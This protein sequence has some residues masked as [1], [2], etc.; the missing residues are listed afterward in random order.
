MNG[1]LAFR[2]A[3]NV[4]VVRWTGASFWA[5]GEPR[6][7]KTLNSPSR[8][9]VSVWAPVRG[10]AA[11][12]MFSM[13]RGLVPL[14]VPAQKNRPRSA[15]AKLR[16]WSLASTQKRSLE[17]K[18]LKLSEFTNPVTGHEAFSSLR[19]T[20]KRYQSFFRIF[21]GS[22]LWRNRRRQQF[23]HL[24]TVCST[25]SSF[26]LGEWTGGFVIHT[27]NG[28]E[29]HHQNILFFMISSNQKVK[30]KKTGRNLFSLQALKLENALLRKRLQHM[31]AVVL[32]WSKHR[33]KQWDLDMFSVP[34]KK[35]SPVWPWRF[36][37]QL[38]WNMAKTR[39][40]GH[41]IVRP[42][43]VAT[44]WTWPT[45]SR[46]GPKLNNWRLLLNCQLWFAVTHSKAPALDRSFVDLWSNA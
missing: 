44:K 45:T 15:S 34:K 16:V 23:L 1:L 38:C 26:K 29:K 39:G 33:E 28:W 20:V 30:K 5:H 4:R 13:W 11:A 32:F 25:H 14:I 9:S 19:A 37:G 35:T 22:L 42:L 10:T 43:W 31:E 24:K 6:R 12:L 41:Q 7:R 17:W 36:L 18:K 2:P 46:M 3:T 40:F 8:K 21:P 27:K